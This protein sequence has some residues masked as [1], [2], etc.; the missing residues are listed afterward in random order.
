M[1]DIQPLGQP[2][3]WFDLS[4]PAS[5]ALPR[6][7]R[8]KV[9]KAQLFAWMSAPLVSI[10]RSIA[11]SSAYLRDCR[12]DTLRTRHCLWLNTTSFELTEDEAKQVKT[13]LDAQP[14]ATAP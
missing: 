4:F 3:S 10:D 8:L 9:S 12:V 6:E 7:L 5:D 14:K 1:S 2:S 13:L 11:Y